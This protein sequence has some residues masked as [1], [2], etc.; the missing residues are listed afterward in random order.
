MASWIPSQATRS[1]RSGDVVSFA[2]DDETLLDGLQRGQPSAMIALFDRYAPLIERI[3]ARILG[4][5]PDLPDLVHEVFAGVLAGAAKVRKADALKDWLTS[6]AVFRARTHIRQRMRRRLWER[7]FGP[8]S[9]PEVPAPPRDDD[10]AEALRA[11]YAVLG[12]LPVDER[13]A[14]ALRTLA[15]MKLTQVAS[16]CDISLATAKRRLARAEQHFLSMAREQPA[17]R[18]WLSGA[19]GE[20]DHV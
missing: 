19:G 15:G 5:D 10:A 16:A 4:A 20:G 11:T 12:R 2:G 9:L 18:A 3:L 1:T 8:E 13:I 6:V 14:F 17:I 7:R